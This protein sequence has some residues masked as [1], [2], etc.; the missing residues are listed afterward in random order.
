[1][2]SVVV[3]IV[4][5]FIV[6]VVL[7]IIGAVIRGSTLKNIK[8]NATQREE[9]TLRNK[10]FVADKT[11]SSEWW[12]VMINKKDKQL[13]LCSGIVSIIP[14][15]EILECEIIE[16]SNT[17][18]KG[19]VGRAI[20]GGVIAG[21]V[22]A[23]VGASTRKSSNI[24]NSL[25][26]RI[27][28]SNIEKPLHTIG[29]ITENTKALKGEMTKNNPYYI[30]SMRFANEVYATVMAIINENK[31]EST[32]VQNGKDESDK[33]FIEEI[34]KLNKLKQD[35]IITEQEFEQGKQKILFASNTDNLKDNS[36]EVQVQKNINKDNE[37]NNIFMSC[38]GSRIET[39]K[40]IS[41][42]KGIGLRE[43]KELFDEW[44]KNN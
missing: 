24:V 14:F 18:K 33:N 42:I 32:N 25:Q 36:N 35:G 29:L 6:I 11:I 43:A 21:G 31:A 28:T 44:E 19:G 2:G 12:R 27:V 39:V 17:I 41:K 26:V 22:G 34:E 40:R 3:F 8:G 15:N 9:D 5:L 16:N 20:V 30:E 37:L 10:N 38:N 23:I 13:A 1:M 7:S 4:I